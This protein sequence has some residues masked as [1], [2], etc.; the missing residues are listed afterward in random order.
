MLVIQVALTV[1]RRSC[2][3]QHSAGHLT[4]SRSMTL[5]TPLPWLVITQKPCLAWPARQRCALPPCCLLYAEQ[6]AHISLKQS[7]GFHLLHL[8]WR[9]S[10]ICR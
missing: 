9:K 4:T 8:G 6:Q 3:V 10:A 2:Q 1:V 5:L 7:F